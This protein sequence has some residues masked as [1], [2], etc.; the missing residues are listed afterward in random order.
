MTAAAAKVDGIADDIPPLEV[1]D[2]SGEAELLVLGWGS[3]LGHDHGAVGTRQSEGSE[4]RDGPSPAPEPVPGQH[5]RGRPEVREGADPRDEH[6]TA[7]GLSIRAKFLVDA[8]SYTKV[9]G[10][11]IFAEELEARD[12]EGAR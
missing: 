1:E 3:S 11:P 9:Q 8:Q 6:G 5:G 10:L 7:R 2:P 12:R 4:R